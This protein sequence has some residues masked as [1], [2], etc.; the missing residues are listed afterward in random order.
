MKR[1]TFL[2]TAAAGVTTIALAGCSTS[3]DGSD[4]ASGG[5]N[6]DSGSDDSGDEETEAE[7]TEESDEPDVKILDHE[8][9]YDADDMGGAKVTGT[10][11]NT[12]DSEMGYMQVQVRFFDDS[13]TRI[14]EGMW[15]ATDVAADTEVEFETIPAMVD[16]E[17]ASYEVE[18]S[19]SP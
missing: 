13:D 15:N 10:V 11:K 4:E 6:D 17:P 1:R 14:G 12:T 3:E 18:T 8:M 2:T 9:V 7:T 19:T 5:N 16:N